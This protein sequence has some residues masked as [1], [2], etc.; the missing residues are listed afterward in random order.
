MKQWLAF[1]KMQ[2]VSAEAFFEKIK[3]VKNHNELKQ[4]ITKELEPFT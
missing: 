4:L 1:F 3:R 2:H